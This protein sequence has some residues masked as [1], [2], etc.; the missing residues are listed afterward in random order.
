MNIKDLEYFISVAECGSFSRASAIL[1]RPQPALSRHIRD[2]ETLLHVKLL[3][4]NG[5]GVVMTDAGRCLKQLGTDIIRQIHEAH[6]KVQAYSG[7]CVTSAV[8]GM[9]ASVSST[10][11]L[12]LPRSLQVTYE[13][14]KFRFIDA[15]N[16]DLLQWLNSGMLD[17]A[18]LYDTQVSASPNMESLLSQNLC[19][20]EGIASG[21]ESGECGYD[22]IQARALQDIPLILPSKRHGLRQIVEGWIAK[23]DIKLNVRLDCDS[24]TSL[25]QLV[26][27]NIGA[28]ILPASCLR[29]EIMAGQFSARLIV[30]PYLFRTISLATSPNK[31]V[32]SLLVNHIKEQIDSLGDEFRWPFTR[33]MSHVG[34]F[35]ASVRMPDVHFK[36]MLSQV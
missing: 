6:D 21:Q 8:I 20:I 13:N 5:R 30:A 10:L 11:A 27:S 24:Y 19:L 26:S 12:P 31:P 16:G 18:L 36:E 34:A 3:Y 9:P 15:Y 14:L 7:G 23:H 17:I 28:T 22:S 33:D 35:R 25:L 4:R 1:G 29:R 32:N 2:L